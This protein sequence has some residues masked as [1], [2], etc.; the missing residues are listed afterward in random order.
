MRLKIL[1]PSEVFADQAGVSSIVAE[2]RSGSFGI[3]EHR[4][5]CVAALAPGILTYKTESQEPIY[6]AVAEGVLVKTGADVF[7]SVRQAIRG[8]DLAE[9]HEAVKQKF[10]KLDQ[11][12]RKVRDMVARMESGFIGRLAE[13][14]R[15]R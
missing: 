11:E 2:S 7:V 15:G 12:E 4:S 1:I 14:Q 5:D 10:L 9:L 3:L 13:F 6:L 8:T